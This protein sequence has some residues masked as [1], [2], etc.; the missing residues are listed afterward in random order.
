MVTAQTVKKS[1]DMQWY[2][3]ACNMFKDSS[4][5]SMEKQIKHS[6]YGET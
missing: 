4:W 2:C 3:S 5:K 1:T 6:F